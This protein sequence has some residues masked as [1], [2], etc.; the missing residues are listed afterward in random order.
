LGD[1]EFYA[2][3]D[4]ALCDKSEAAG[5]LERDPSLIAVRNSV[6]ETALHYLV[7]ENELAS[8][9]WLVDRGADVN[10]RDDFGGT[11]LMHAAVLGY[12]ELCEFLLSRG[13]IIEIHDDNGETAISKVA[14][15]GKREALDMLLSRLP[16]DADIN[17]YFDELS[18]DSTLKH[19]GEIAELLEARGLKSF[20][21]RWQ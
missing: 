13:A 7:V 6:G 19:G 18:A 9:E 12:M 15:R 10:T 16:V 1:P 4:A 2:F 5:M 14:E 3:R 21:E 20:E 8:V 17:T 11:P